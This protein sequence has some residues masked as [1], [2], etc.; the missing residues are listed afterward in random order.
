MIVCCQEEDATARN[1]DAEEADIRSEEENVSRGES[2]ATDDGAAATDDATARRYDKTE[3][4]LAGEPR[5]EGVGEGGADD[6]REDTTEL[7]CSVR[8]LRRQNDQKTPFDKRSYR[9][10][11]KFLGIP[12]SIDV[13]PHSKRRTGLVLVAFAWRRSYTY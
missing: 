10:R 9:G 2:G 3:K 6:Q 13:H 12:L 11:K 1:G 8:E 5:L 7:P 4:V